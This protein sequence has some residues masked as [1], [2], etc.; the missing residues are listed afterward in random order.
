MQPMPA[1]NRITVMAGVALLALVVG[2]FALWSSRKSAESK[3]NTDSVAMT[4]ETA[5]TTSTTPQNLTTSPTTTGTTGASVTPTTPAPTGVSGAT[6]T[7]ATLPTTY[8][9]QPGDTLST[10]SMK[11]YNSDKYYGDIE[12]A[13]ELEDANHL[14]VGQTLQI[15]DITAATATSTTH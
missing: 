7:T 11:Y 15:P 6:G 10:I 3:P 1:K 13:N 4:D 12:A 5:T 2:G 8:V 14:V 9:V